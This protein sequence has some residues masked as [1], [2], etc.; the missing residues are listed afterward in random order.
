[1]KVWKI[2]PVKSSGKYD[3]IPGSRD[4]VITPIGT[5]IVGSMN[6]W[7]DDL[8]RADF[9]VILDDGRWVRM[10]L[11]HMRLIDRLGEYTG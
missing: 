8:P 7:Y 1:M 4:R 3:W 2:K 5:G 9:T 10:G 6:V 11:M